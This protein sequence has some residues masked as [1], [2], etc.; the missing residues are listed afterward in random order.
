MEKKKKTIILSVFVII[1]SFSFV[2]TRGRYVYNY[3]KEHMLEA[4]R[5]YF[6]SPS[7]SVNGTTHNI[8]N[9]DGVNEYTFNI[10]LNTYK[11]KYVKT[12]TDVDYTVSVECSS[13][14]TCESSKT[15]GKISPN[16]STDSYT[17]T[18]NPKSNLKS[19]DTA[20]ITTTA[21][22]KSPYVKSIKTTYNFTITTYHFSYG[23][24][25]MTNQIYLE[26]Y[27]ENAFSYYE[28][29]EA[30]DTH[31]VGDYISSD[32]YAKLSDA[33]KAKCKSANVTLTWD[34]DKY[35]IDMNSNTYIDNASSIVKDGDNVKGIT[36]KMKATT[37][38]K[39][40]FFKKDITEDNTYPTVKTSSVIGVSVDSVT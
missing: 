31:K 15:S 23:I 9:W 24:D 20:S 27:L 34:P 40:K 36:I 19:G 38:E 18:I 3:I 12:E 28:V 2:V 35:R 29:E 25:D 22:S 26:L 33:N 16:S 39:I 21:T 5:F 10:S 11:N 17:I 8:T 13:N 7:M 6:N 37:T 4:K 32:D 1:V 14:I 30:F